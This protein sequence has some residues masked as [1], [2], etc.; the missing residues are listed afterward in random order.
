MAV[1]CT[2][3][4]MTIVERPVGHVVSWGA[5]NP[6]AVVRE[7]GYTEAGWTLFCSPKAYRELVD[8]PDFSSMP[9]GG[10]DSFL[11]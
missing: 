11:G 10:D 8:H 9:I 5:D 2:K 4:G 6:D 1:I 7:T 3:T